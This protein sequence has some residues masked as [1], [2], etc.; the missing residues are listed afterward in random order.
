MAIDVDTVNVFETAPDVVG[1]TVNDNVGVVDADVVIEDVVVAQIVGVKV[2]ENVFVTVDV[3][4]EDV[5]IV[6]DTVDEDERVSVR[7]DVGVGI[8][9]RDV[10]NEAVKD[11]EPVVEAELLSDRDTDT[12]TVGEFDDENNN[13]S[14]LVTLTASDTADVGDADEEADTLTELV[15]QLEV[16]CDADLVIVVVT[17]I[18]DVDETVGEKVVD[19]V[20]ELVD[21]GEIERV[22][23]TEFVSEAVPQ[24][25]TVPLADRDT[26]GDDERD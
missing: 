13:D 1:V 24:E 10:D 20:A 9:D 23:V 19:C 14:E 8:D 4:V 21:D 3:P 12:D 5:E 6:P 2:L 16:D 25:E 11:V 26:V 22:R 18:V 17:E 7:D 15:A